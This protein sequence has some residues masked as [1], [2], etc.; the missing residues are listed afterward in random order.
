MNNTLTVEQRSQYGT[1]VW[2]P[3]CDKAKALAK[4]TNTK[5]L[6]AKTLHECKNLGLKVVVNVDLKS[7]FS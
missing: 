5:T 3:V 6:T 2:Y 1:T 7:L 4:I